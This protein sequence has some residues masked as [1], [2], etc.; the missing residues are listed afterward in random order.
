MLFSCKKHQPQSQYDRALS[1]FFLVF[2]RLIRKARLILSYRSREVTQIEDSDTEQN[3]TATR[4][5]WLNVCYC[6]MLLLLMLLRIKTLS[7]SLVRYSSFDVI[8]GVWIYLFW[9]ST[10]YKYII[11]LLMCILFYAKY[12]LWDENAQD[13]FNLIVLCDCFM[14]LISLLLKRA[15]WFQTL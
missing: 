10:S 4:R 9:S 1:I 3:A 11:V 5:V 2:I 14:W 6:S 13:N 12:P 7:I 15:N 8:N